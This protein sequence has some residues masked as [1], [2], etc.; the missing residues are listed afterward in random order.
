MKRERMQ[1]VA[2]IGKRGGNHVRINGCSC[3]WLAPPSN[4]DTDDQFAHHHARATTQQHESLRVVAAKACCCGWVPRNGVGLLDHFE[5]AN[6]RPSLLNCDEDSDSERIYKTMAP[7]PGYTPSRT[8]HDEIDYELLT[9]EHTD[10]LIVRDL[11]DHFVPFE[12]RAEFDRMVVSMLVG[13]I[14]GQGFYG[15]IHSDPFVRVLAFRAWGSRDAGF[16]L[17]IE[18]PGARKQRRGLLGPPIQNIPAQPKA[19]T[20]YRNNVLHDRYCTDETCDGQRCAK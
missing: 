17:P 15:G 2:V 11:R 20:S 7:R 8:V 19:L 18:R 4:A 1:H 3:G 13:G 9:Q 10:Y 6:Y 5:A 12:E 14:W 16:Q